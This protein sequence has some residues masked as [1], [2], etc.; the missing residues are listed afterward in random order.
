MDVLERAGL[1]FGLGMDPAV[2]SPDK[3]DGVEYSIYVRH[4]DEPYVLHRVFQRYIDPKNN[5]DDRHWFDER[6]GLSPF[7]GQAVD[8]IFEA[9][10]GSAGDATYDWGGWSTPVLVDESLPGDTGAGVTSVLSNT[11]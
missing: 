1:H 5:P 6:V 2:W 7:G 8:I 10:P 9:L 3:G 4:P 11:P